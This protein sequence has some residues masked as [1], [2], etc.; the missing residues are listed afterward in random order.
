MGMAVQMHYRIKGC[1]NSFAF[2]LFCFL[3]Y[4]ATPVERQASL[5]LQLC[6]TWVP[7][8][9]KVCCTRGVVLY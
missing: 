4:S 7:A 5:S 6:R 3:R 9:Q 2:V 1:E 8:A